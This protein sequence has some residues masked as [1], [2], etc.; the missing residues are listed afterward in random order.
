MKK[1]SLLHLF[2]IAILLSFAASC[3]TEQAT[4]VDQA[5]LAAQMQAA[6]QPAVPTDPNAILPVDPEITT[7]KLENGLRY[8][9]RRNG[10]P[11]D[12]AEIRHAVKPGSVLEDEDHR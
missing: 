2:L 3:A 4:L 10:V 7:G 9:I 6:Q 8:Y 5:E 11:A 12:R 1:T